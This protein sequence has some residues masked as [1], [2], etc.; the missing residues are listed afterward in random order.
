MQTSLGWV[1]GRQCDLGSKSLD[2]PTVQF[3]VFKSERL[4]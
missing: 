4:D 1:P 3:T 2:L